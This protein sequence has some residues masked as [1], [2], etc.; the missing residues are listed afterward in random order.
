[1]ENESKTLATIWRTPDE[2]W[3]R[4]EPVILTKDPPKRKGRKRV[5]PRMGLDTLIHRLRSGCQWNQLPGELADDSSA[6]RTL[7]RWHELGVFDAVWALLVESCAEIGGV[8]WGWQA[9]DAA[10]GKSRLGGIKLGPIPPTGAK[11][12]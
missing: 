6:H 3:E 4:I 9:A 12:A 11:L 1:M 5:A 2:L 8:D 10:L 7:Q